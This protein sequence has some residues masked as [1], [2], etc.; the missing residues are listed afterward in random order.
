MVQKRFSQ[1][2]EIHYNRCQ[3]KGENHAK[4]TRPEHKDISTMEPQRTFSI[5][6]NWENLAKVLPYVRVQVGIIALY[7][8]FILRAISLLGGRLRD[9]LT[10]T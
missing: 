9:N 7:A 10:I 1:G 3:S 2:S 4:Y 8:E 6:I 5:K